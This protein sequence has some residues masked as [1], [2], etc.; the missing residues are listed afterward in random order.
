MRMPLDSLRVENLAG[1]A[2]K[3]IDLTLTQ[4]ARVLGLVRG[5]RAVPLEGHRGR[6]GVLIEGRGFSRLLQDDVLVGAGLMRFAGWNT[7]RP[8]A[9]GTRQQA[10]AFMGYMRLAPRMADRHARQA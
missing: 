2:M 7:P 5:I 10:E 4:L 8:R 1:I 3:L 9:F 6:W